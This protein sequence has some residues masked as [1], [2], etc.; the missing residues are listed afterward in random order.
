MRSGGEYTPRYLRPMV[1][2]QVCDFFYASIFNSGCHNSKEDFQ[3]P[4][5]RFEW[6][7]NRL[8]GLAQFLCT[9]KYAIATNRGRAQTARLIH[10]EIQYSEFVQC[11]AAE[12]LCSTT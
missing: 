2:R 8:F 1:D 9:A 7:H 10:L 6:M 12:A 5:I 3:E 11:Q 4:R